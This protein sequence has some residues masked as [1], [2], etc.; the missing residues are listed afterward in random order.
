M[1]GARKRGLKKTFGSIARREMV[2]LFHHFEARGGGIDREAADRP[3]GLHGFGELRRRFETLEAGQMTDH[4]A[5]ARCARFLDQ[6]DSSH[7]A[8]SSGAG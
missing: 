8:A 1:A 7:H 2:E 4:H 5:G 3:A 6:R